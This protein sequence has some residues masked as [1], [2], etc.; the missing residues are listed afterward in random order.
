MFAELT[1]SVVVV[2]RLDLLDILQLPGQFERGVEQ[3]REAM[4]AKVYLLSLV[5]QGNQWN[6]VFREIAIQ[7]GFHFIAFLYTCRRP[8]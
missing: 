4:R 7:A 2:C 5:L 3:Y 8:H 1:R 6:F